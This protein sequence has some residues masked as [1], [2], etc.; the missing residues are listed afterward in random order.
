LAQERNSLIH[1]ELALL[2]FEDEAECAALSNKLNAQNERI[3]RATKFLGPILTQMREL[4]RLIA[5]DQRLMQELVSPTLMEE[6][7]E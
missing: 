1:L 2:N 7:A 6:D 3:I 5:S 4:A